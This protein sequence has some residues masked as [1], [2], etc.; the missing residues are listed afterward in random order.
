MSATEIGKNTALR[1]QLEERA[2]KWRERRERLANM[3]AQMAGG[4]PLFW[5]FLGGVAVAIA[6]GLGYDVLS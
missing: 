4:N 6:A 2:L 3:G 1:L 5:R